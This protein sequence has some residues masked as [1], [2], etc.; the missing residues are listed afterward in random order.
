MIIKH[1]LHI[2]CLGGNKTRLD[3]VQC[4]YWIHCVSLKARVDFP[5]LSVGTS[6]LF[7]YCFWYV[8]FEAGSLLRGILSS[9]IL[10]YELDGYLEELHR[11]WFESTGCLKDDILDPTSGG[12]DNTVTIAHVRGMLTWILSVVLVYPFGI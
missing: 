5:P 3:L 2:F 4:V 10:A 9:K 1:E 11:K 8:C 7:S 6:R 12:E